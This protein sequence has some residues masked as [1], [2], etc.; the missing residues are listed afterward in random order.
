MKKRVFQVFATV[1]SL[2]FL[3]LLR[4]MKFDHGDAYTIKPEMRLGMIAIYYAQKDYY[5]LHG[6]YNNL[7]D[8]HEFFKSKRIQICPSKELPSE[9]GGMKCELTK[10]SF[11]Y[12][13]RANL[14]GVEEFEVWSIDSLKNMNEIIKDEPWFF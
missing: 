10:N 8:P 14:N 3:L 7:L 1:I 4:R 11:I 6:V 9:I 13:V 5:A 12:I 2:L